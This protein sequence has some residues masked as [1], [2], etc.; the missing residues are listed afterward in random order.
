[1]QLTHESRRT[2][3]LA[4]AATW[5]VCVILV[6]LHTNAVRD[7]LQMLD[8]MGRREGVEAVTP[9]R[10][11]VP[12]RYAD[13]QMWVRHAIA[14]KASDE[15]RL[16]FT[17]DDNAPH[18]REVHWASPLVWLLRTAGRITD[19]EQTLRWFNAPLLL[20]FIVILSCWTRRWAG[21][22]A[23]VLVA[24]AMVG[25][26]RF[27]A[28]FAPANV[29]H[30]G[31]LA[32]CVLGLVLG[33]VF[34]GAGWWKP[35][36]GGAF[37][38]LLP[39]DASRARRAAIVSALCGATGLWIS[40]ASMLPAIA[41]G[42]AAGLVIV[43]WL[44]GS[45]ERDGARFEPGIWQLWGRV[46]AAASLVFYLV[47]YA[48]SH[49]GLRLEVNHPL[50]ALAWWGGAEIV[51]AAGA[52]RMDR[53]RFVRRQLAW[54][55]ILPVLAVLAVPVVIFKGG[56]RV[57]ML[58]D[59]F[60]AG[61]RHFVIEGKSL[62]AAA[63]SFGI[64]AVAYPLASCLILI[65]A[66]VIGWRA[67]GE[68]ATLLGFAAL[69][70]AGFMALGFWEM[71]WW[72]VGSATQIALLVVIVASTRAR[73]WWV[74]ALSGLVLLPASVQRVAAVRTAVRHGVV[75]ERDAL[76]PLYRDLA[77]TIRATQ[78]TGDI[79]LLASPNASMG[80]G[81]HGNFKTIGTLFWENAPGL[82]TAAAIFSAHTDD[83]A[84]A[85]VRARGITH[86]AMVSAASF[87]SEYFLLLHPAADTGAGKSTFG[88]R[89]ATNRSDASWLQP[90]PYRRPGDLAIAETTV[91]LYKVSFDQTELDRL[92]HIAVARA[93]GGDLAGAEASLNETLARIPPD[94]RFDFAASVGEAFH[95][96]G[97]DAA[98]V[99]A[100]RRAL[101]F[102][103]DAG[104]ATT[105]AWILATTSD[106]KLRDGRSA[107]NLIDPVA[108]AGLDDPTVLNALAAALAEVGRFPDAVLMMQRALSASGAANDP[109]AV[110]LMQQRLDSYRANKPWRP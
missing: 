108:Q 40:A 67:R 38:T 81:Y 35:N 110:R 91:W 89:L 6:L 90:I 43:V 23:G 13:A 98:A 80:I 8:G 37:T 75:E 48:P 59:P 68:G 50:Y 66:V 20:G 21:A 95:D 52:M 83:E 24:M 32:V 65:P 33:L 39:N 3:W 17:R 47:E 94:A 104:I 26:N 62:P 97:A 102:K 46:G 4:I 56:D 61:L 72:F 7:Y 18:G 54:R 31:L 71:R 103:P 34:M 58:G 78:P 30:H 82:E 29:D 2:W 55:S 84:A 79:T 63:R 10:H 92:Y 14:A 51:A 9:M 16:R 69:I 1:M 53:S 70:A 87:L 106:E 101:T 73:W 109:A 85:L 27:L 93:A 77:G 22:A 28:T 45:A 5:S 15:T 100:F 86:I 42:G 44:G 76:Q 57:F 60:V 25:H 88:H 74:L 12:S 41:I 49:L 107:L 96:Y 105:L 11:I 99:R 19:I 64:G 36:L